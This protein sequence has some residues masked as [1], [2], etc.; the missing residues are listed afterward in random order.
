MSSGGGGGGGGGGVGGGGGGGGGGGRGVGV[1]YNLIFISGFLS[2][3]T[4]VVA[5]ACVCGSWGASVSQLRDI[6]ARNH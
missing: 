3:G 2:H 1:Y 6:C 5:C 4:V